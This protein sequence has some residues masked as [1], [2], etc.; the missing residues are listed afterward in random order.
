MK[1]R[2]GEFDEF[3]RQDKKQNSRKEEWTIMGHRLAEGAIH[4]IVV[5]RRLALRMGEDLGNRHRRRIM[6]MGLSYVRLESK[7]NQDQ[8]SDE[9]PT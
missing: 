8:A 3:Y 5:K 4:G 7:S 1:S 2:R 9:A 6:N